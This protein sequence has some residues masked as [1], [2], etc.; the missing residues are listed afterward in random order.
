MPDDNEALA[1]IL[2]DDLQYSINDPNGRTA[3]V[4]SPMWAMADLRET[5]MDYENTGESEGNRRA[6][7]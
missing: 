6:D 1:D 2:M 4:Y 5:L 3:L 7:T